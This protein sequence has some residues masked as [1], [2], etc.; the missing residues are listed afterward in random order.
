MKV[1]DGALGDTVGTWR[2]RDGLLLE[3]ISVYLPEKKLANPFL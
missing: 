3:T 2:V 1:K